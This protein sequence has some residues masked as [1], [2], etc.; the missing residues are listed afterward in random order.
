VLMTLIKAWNTGHPG[1]LVTLHANSADEVPGRLR[2]LATEVMAT[3][4]VP[5]LM[6]ATDLI[7][8]IRRDTARPTLAKI[9]ATVRVTDG[10]G[11]DSYRMETLHEAP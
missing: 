1:G 4:P 9:L 2:L 3:D 6:E 11:N 10:P 8:F 5:A 7:A